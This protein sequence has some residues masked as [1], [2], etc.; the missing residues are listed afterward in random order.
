MLGHQPHPF[1]DE[2]VILLT[3]P[4][5]LPLTVGL[6]GG[7]GS[8]KSSLLEL[9]RVEL[10]NDPAKHLRSRSVQ[11]VA[12]RGIRRHQGRADDR[13][14][15]QPRTASSTRYCGS[16]GVRQATPIRGETA[17]ARAR[18]RPG[19]CPGSGHR[20]GDADRPW[21]GADGR[22]DGPGRVRRSGHCAT[23]GGSGS[24]DRRRSQHAGAGISV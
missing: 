24:R 10:E 3:E 14:P 7:W 18:G 4:R 17:T 15:R 6:L 13:D 19:G 11:P 2:L 20:S 8:G 16:R 21:C 5:L 9:T 12:V 22:H 23:R 1:L